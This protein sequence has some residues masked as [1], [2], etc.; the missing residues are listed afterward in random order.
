[1]LATIF[2]SYVALAVGVQINVDTSSVLAHSDPTRF[3]SFSF[4]FTALW[5]VQRTFIPF[6]NEKL[7]TLARNLA[8]SFVRFG[9]S[10]QDRAVTRFAGTPQPPPG[11]P[12]MLVLDM[13][14]TVFDGLVD[15]ATETGL[16]LVYGL[17]AAVGRQ[18]ADNSSAPWDADNALAPIRRAA[19]M[20]MRFPV[21]ELSNECN[22]FNCSKDGSAKMSPAQLVSQYVTLAALVRTLLPGTQIWGSD[23]S[24][25]GDVFG[26]CHDYYGDDI[27]GFN[28][29]LFAIPQF[30]SLLDAHT[31]H[32]YSQDSRNATSTASLILTPEYQGRLPAYHAQAKAAKDTTAPGLP[33]V[34]GET[35]SFWA[36]GKA[37]VSNR[38][39]SGFWYLP[40][41]G[42]LASKGYLTHIRQDLA[43]GDYGLVDLVLDGQG[44]VVDF[45]PN[46]DYF[47]HA[48][49]QR[50]MGGAS[51]AVNVT[52]TG[53]GEE[54]RAW[55]ACGG[56]E[57]GAST[58]GVSIVVV[59]F[60]ATPSDPVR[61]TL[62]SG[63]GGAQPDTWG[64][65][66][67]TPGD[68]AGGLES[69]TMALN[70]VVLEVE[71]G[72]WL[73][74]TM[75]PSWHNAK[76]DLVLPPLSYAFITLPTAMAQGCLGA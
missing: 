71:E 15:F 66:S 67:L 69:A 70:G 9:G 30:P 31:W 33:M 40:Q 57:A 46:P 52:Q 58:G 39:A 63:G 22:V 64:V 55:G 19:A 26:Q 60:A 42:F 24:I 36:G 34:M 13:N 65:F 61:I 49:W 8:P 35:A 37:N 1:M 44:V 16:D 27:F 47:T 72:S 73:L 5:G 56:R 25:T 20:G 51:L 41:L 14:E 2:L 62:G 59:N 32:Y 4:D 28:R 21:V 3:A 53:G 68:E 54:V 74:P 10:F 12:T 17:N 50:L 29:D 6:T 23:S 7:R 11:P 38:F 75:A 18:L 43:G 48:L 76:D 45:T